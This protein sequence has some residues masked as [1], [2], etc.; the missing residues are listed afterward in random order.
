MSAK[1]AMHLLAKAISVLVGSI[2]EFV[3]C[4]F[5]LFGMITIIQKFNSKPLL[6]V[7]V[8]ILYVAIVISAYFIVVKRVK[9]A[10]DK[11]QA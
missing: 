10:I 7:A 8:T 9:S 1:S 2:I 5:V 4:G 11:K 6:M 3:Y